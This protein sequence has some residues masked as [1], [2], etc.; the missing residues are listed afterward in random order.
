[1]SLVK[2]EAVHLTGEEN[3]HFSLLSFP[4]LWS[5]TYLTHT[6][7]KAIHIAF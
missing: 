3:M 1:M 7:L 5:H 6:L 4:G 2:E